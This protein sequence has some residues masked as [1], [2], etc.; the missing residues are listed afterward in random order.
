MWGVGEQRARESRA[1]ESNERAKGGSQ[2]CWWKTESEAKAVKKGDGRKEWM[3]EE[4]ED[5]N[6]RENLTRLLS[7]QTSLQRGHYSE[8]FRF[9]HALL[10]LLPTVSFCFD[11]MPRHCGIATPSPSSSISAARSFF[12]SVPF[13]AFPVMPSTTSSMQDIETLHRRAC[14]AGDTFYTDPTTGLS[15][16]TS[17]FLSKRPCCS[18]GCR[19]C[20]YSPTAISPPRVLHGDLEDVSDEVDVLFWSGGKDSFLALL[21]L[22]R[23]ALRSVILLTTYHEQNRMVAQ[24]N[25]SIQSVIDFVAA[26]GLVLVGVPLGGEYVDRVQGALHKIQNNGIEV[27]RMVFGDLHLP[28]V[29]KWR[30]SH[31]SH[32]APLYF[33]LWKMPYSALLSQLQAAKVR[34]SISAVDKSN[35]S[36]RHIQPGHLFDAAFLDKLPQ[37]VDQFGENGEFHTL[38]ESLTLLQ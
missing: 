18:S 7:N 20:P 12:L 5:I 19:H 34:V 22:Q 17:H 23:E 2:K 9:E 25:V 1:M 8:H 15:V 27:K 33:P 31:L 21:Q 35:L 32:L 24:Q 30:E 11:P 37:D 29:R 4:E 10:A 6:D 38:V 16:F 26:R 14:D 3:G 36:L 13:L 28:H